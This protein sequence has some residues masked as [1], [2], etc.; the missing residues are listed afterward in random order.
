MIYEA[1]DFVEEQE[2]NKYNHDFV[3]YVAHKTMKKALLEKKNAADKELRSLK[4]QV[5][6]MP[7]FAVYQKINR[8]LK[9]EVDL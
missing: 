7:V 3:T 2:K 5:E 4:D 8:V 6:G 9:L 1:L